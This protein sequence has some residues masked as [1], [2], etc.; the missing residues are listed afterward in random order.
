MDLFQ[1]VRTGERVTALEAVRDRLAFLL[2]DADHRTAA[3]LAKQLAEV[4]R[5]LESLAPERK[6]DTVDDLSARREARRAKAAGG[7]SSP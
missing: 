5:E 6:A 2:E 7:E 3:G 1:A 4:M